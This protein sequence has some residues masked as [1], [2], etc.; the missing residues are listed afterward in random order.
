[1]TASQLGFVVG[2]L[3]AI[4][5]PTLPNVTLCLGT[6]AEPSP[7]GASPPGAS[8]P[9]ASPPGASASQT[10]ALWP[11]LLYLSRHLPSIFEHLRASLLGP[12]AAVAAAAAMAAEDAMEAAK[13][14]GEGEEVGKAAVKEEDEA[15]ERGGKRAK[16][17][18]AAGSRAGGGSVG[19]GGDADPFEQHTIVCLE[20]MEEESSAF[21]G[22]ILLSSHLLHPASVIEAARPLRLSVGLALCRSWLMSAVWLGSW[23]DAWILMAVEGRFAHSLCAH[24]FGDDEAAHRLAEERREVC[25]LGRQADAVALVP[26]GDELERWGGGLHPEQLFKPQRVR[27]APLVFGM[28][29]KAVMRTDGG[30][31]TWDA[32]MARLVVL[33]PPVPPPV[34]PP[35]DA[36][37]GA[38]AEEEEGEERWLRRILL[39][40]R[41]VVTPAAAVMRARLSSDITAVT[42]LRHEARW[43]RLT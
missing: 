38:A 11:Q 4:A 21:G 6:L 43:R 29:E 41:P 33:P 2:R 17:A 8:P 40:M 25:G 12:C 19:G 35:E 34:P 42:A 27:K 18:A 39:F 28:L 30:K 13:A 32:L 10:D 26:D 5:H 20:G 7:P 9:G 24:E 37:G 14:T 16:T 22:L 1:M 23:R 31:R 3:S 15:A 36:G